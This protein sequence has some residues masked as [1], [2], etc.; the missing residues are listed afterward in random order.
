M[1]NTEADLLK[2]KD[3]GWTINN[4]EWDDLPELNDLGNWTYKNR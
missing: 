2:M 1:A 3:M 4:P